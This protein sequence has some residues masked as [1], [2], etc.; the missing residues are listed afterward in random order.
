MTNSPKL[1]DNLHKKL[2]S[3]KELLDLICCNQLESGAFKSIVHLPHTRYEDSNAFITALVLRHA[4]ILKLNE[5]LPKVFERAVHFLRKCESKRFPGMY[6]FWPEN[7]HP[8]WI[9]SFK[10]CE[11]A[12]DSSIISLEL[13]EYGLENQ[14]YIKKLAKKVLEQHRFFKSGLL[15][16]NWENTGAFLTWLHYSEN[17]NPVDCCVNTNIVALLASCGLKDMPGYDEACCMV[18]NAVLNSDGKMQAI[19]KLSPYYPHAIEL[20]FAVQYA[21]RIGGDLEPALSYLYN[22]KWVQAYLNGGI[23]ADQH[24]CS[25]QNGSIVWTSEIL[26]AIRTYELIEEKKDTIC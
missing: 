5:V 20:F 26:Q 22:Q 21:V 3:K 11:D 25:H 8:F 6:R 17:P 16:N 24:I 4:R 10:I 13:V 23:D 14:S 18:N 7:A 2:L 12:D 19:T 1:N 15:S 9:G